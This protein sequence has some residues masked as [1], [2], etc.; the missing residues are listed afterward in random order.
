VIPEDGGEG[1]DRNEEGDEEHGPA[2][3]T[4]T[5]LGRRLTNAS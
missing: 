5:P 2:S 1:E 3:G 4:A